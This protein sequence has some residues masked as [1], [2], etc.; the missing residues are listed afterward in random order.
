VPEGPDQNQVEIAEGET[1]PGRPRRKS[2]DFLVDRRGVAVRTE[3]LQLKPFGGVTAILLSG[4]PGHT[5]R[6][7]GGVGPAFGALESDHDP[8]ALVFSHE[9]RCA[10]CAMRKDK[11]TPYLPVV[12]APN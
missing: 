4:V 7:L 11:L 3:L 9:G 2:L 12:P 6:T 5:G 1:R 8:D 10:A